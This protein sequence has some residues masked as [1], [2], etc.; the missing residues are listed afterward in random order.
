MLIK[1]VFPCLLTKLISGTL[2]GADD[3]EQQLREIIEIK[4]TK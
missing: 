2:V 1:A 4:R 3:C